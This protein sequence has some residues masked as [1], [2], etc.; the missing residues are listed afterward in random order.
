MATSGD[1]LLATSGD[2][3]MATDTPSRTVERGANQ[4]KHRR[5]LAAPAGNGRETNS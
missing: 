2:F 1:F 3:H 5:P 4:H